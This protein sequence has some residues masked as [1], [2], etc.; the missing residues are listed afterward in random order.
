[1]WVEK[2]G[3]VYRIR[4][5]VAGKK[6]TL[7][8]GFATKTAANA[9]MT[10]LKAD[11]LRGDALVPRGGEV[12]V[13][14][15]LDAWWPAYAAS[16]KPSSRISADG[17]IRRYIR[18]MLGALALEDVG[19]LAVQRWTAD[20]LAGK[21]AAGKPLAVKTVRNAHGL[22][23]KVM[24][25]AV[26]QRLI[27]ANPCE[28]TGLPERQHREMR[29]LDH[30]EAARL[31]AAMPEHWRPLIILLLGTGLRWGEAIGLRAG[32]VDVLARRLR[33]EETMQ[34]LA[35]TAEIV[36]VPP[37]SRM[38]RRSVGFTRNV[39]GA[40][41]PLV[42]NKDRAALVFTAPRGGPVRYRVFR[43]TW[44]AATAAA[45]L[46]GLRIH[47][48]RH[49]HAAWLISDGVPLTA[50]QRRLGHASISVTSD[51]YGHLLGA[52]DEAIDSTVD[53]AMG[54]IDFGGELGESSPDETGATRSQPE[55]P[56]AQE[57]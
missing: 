41:V 43:K 38:S 11:E 5:L 30:A 20:L 50:V 22:L 48:L 10:T 2:H 15:W 21:T 56:A 25:E 33:V 23:H 13:G 8:G 45:G 49:T 17:L 28:R 7:K 3:K 53:E 31:V 18:P 12:V 42:A 55:L 6:V 40:L 36:F 39:A 51:L 19:T 1:M 26:A 44:V 27:R 4:D 35:D 47:D 9:V 32:R 14:E 29:F 24:S 54:M 34:E 37:K 57:G 16:L 52:V 46:T